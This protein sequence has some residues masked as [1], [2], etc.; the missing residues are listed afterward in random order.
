MHEDIPLLRR[1]VCEADG[2]VSLARR[3]GWSHMPEGRGGG[4][5]Q[6]HRP[7]FRVFHGIFHI[8]GL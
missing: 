6:N 4:L 2:V 3:A 1:G 8:H 7:V 5:F